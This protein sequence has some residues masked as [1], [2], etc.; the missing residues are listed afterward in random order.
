MAFAGLAGIVT[1]LGL[2][3]VL[4]L[5]VFLRTKGSSFTFDPAGNDGEF[6]KTLLPIYLDITKF[7]A[8]LAA[9]SI[10]FCLFGSSNFGPSNTRSLKSFASP[11]FVVAMSIIYGVLEI[12]RMRIPIPDSNTPGTRH[13]GSALS[14]ASALVTLGWSSRRPDKGVPQA[15]KGQPRAAARKTRNRSPHRIGTSMHACE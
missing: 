2:F 3:A 10:V 15:S 13:L 12:T 5:I 4:W 7:A 11:L 6:A 8:G 1:A 14:P 9:A